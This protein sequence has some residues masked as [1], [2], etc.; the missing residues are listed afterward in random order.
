MAQAGDTTHIYST[1]KH[2][3]IENYSTRAQ[4][5][6]ICFYFVFHSLKVFYYYFESSLS[7]SAY[8]HWK[9]TINKKRD[10]LWSMN[11]SWMLRW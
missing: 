3:L 8:N 5:T 2:K 11:C 7:T 9:K 4:T 1:L 6:F 10:V